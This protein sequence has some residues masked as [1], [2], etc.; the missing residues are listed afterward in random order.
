MKDKPPPK[1]FSIIAFASGSSQ[2]VMGKA[3][4]P[5]GE[6]Y[7]DVMIANERCDEL[8]EQ[9]AEFYAERDAK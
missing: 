3:K 4:L 2:I 8:N 6:R 7:L 5:V 9:A 1:L